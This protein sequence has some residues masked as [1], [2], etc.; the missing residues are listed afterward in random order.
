MKHLILSA[1][2]CALVGHANA[3]ALVTQVR[4]VG[5][6]FW[7][8]MDNTGNMVIP[9]KYKH[10]FPFGPSGYAAVKDGATDKAGFINIKGEA[11][12]TEVADFTLIS[13]MVKDAQGFS[14]GLAPVRIGEV[15]GFMNTQGKL[16]IAAKYDKVEAFEECLAVVMIGKKQYI[17]TPEGK[18]TAVVDPNIV[19]VKGFQGGLSPF[20]Q[21]D[22]MH[23]FMDGNQNVVIP[24]TF[25]SV[26]Y[27]SGD[28]AWAKTKDAKV[29]YI[30]KKGEWVITP[31]FDDAKDFDPTSGMARVKQGDNWMYVAKDGTIMRVTDTTVWG[32]FSEGLAKGKKGELIG[33]FDKSG[34]WVIEPQFNNVR[35]F[36]NGYAAAR[37]GELWGFIDKT[38]KWVIEPKFEAVKDM[39]KVK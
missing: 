1:A 2:L 13:G 38:G 15:W 33:F 17:L 24:A 8:Y 16:A 39:E 28:L 11:L 21:K 22:K 20:K 25:L 37:Q 30:N 4:Q 31:Q 27:F 14:C 6:E 32:D 12:A 26:G 9:P 23:G 19:D 10:N 18:E 29:G 3:Q 34:K 5:N 35:E 36:K 7:G